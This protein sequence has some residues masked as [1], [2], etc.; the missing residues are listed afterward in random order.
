MNKLPLLPLPDFQLVWIGRA[1]YKVT[2]PNIGDTDVYTAEQMQAYARQALAHGRREAPDV[3]ILR[4]GH[5]NG[6]HFGPTAPVDNVGWK[7]YVALQ[8]AP[9]SGDMS[10]DGK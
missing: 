9:S 6:V 5:G 8:S 2:K 1:L 10:G 3:W 7:P 4:T